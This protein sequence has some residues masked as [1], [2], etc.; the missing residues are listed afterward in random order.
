LQYSLRFSTAAMAPRGEIDMGVR[1][2][3]KH[4]FLAVQADEDF[5]I[6][7]DGVPMRRASRACTAPSLGGRPPLD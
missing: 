1:L 5:E 6:E 3:V 2:V 7:V 4:T